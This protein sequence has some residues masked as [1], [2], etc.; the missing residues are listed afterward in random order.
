MASSTDSIQLY[1]QMLKLD[2]D[3][4]VF[5]LL[6]EELCSAGQWEEAADVCRKGLQSH[7]DHLRSRVLLGW[8]LMEM[9]EAD[10]SGAVLEQIVEEI[11]QSSMIFKLLSEFATFS[12]DPDR[13]AAFSKVYDAFQAPNM[14][15]SEGA[16]TVAPA[17]A[18]EAAP[19]ATAG[20]VKT[21]ERTWPLETRVAAALETVEPAVEQMAESVAA[22]L[23]EKVLMDVDLDVPEEV[24]PLAVKS[25]G[26]P[27]ILSGLA[28]AI[29]LR[30]TAAPAL[31]PMLSGADKDF[32]KKAIIGELAAVMRQ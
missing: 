11:S 4:R 3:S 29:E 23:P 13:A 24:E 10:E 18:P 1:R 5:A 22:S 26:L 17:F 19:D 20:I 12:G 32:L 31:P 2:P 6:A 21:E 7:P 9:G 14:Q 28:D 16:V 27:G 25:P 30:F 8:A 15:M